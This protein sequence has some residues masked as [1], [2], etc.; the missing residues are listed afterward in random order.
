MLRVLI[1]LKIILA[2]NRD[3]L[4]HI[5]LT[6]GLSV[7]VWSSFLLFNVHVLGVIQGLI[8]I[9]NCLSFIHLDIEVPFVWRNVDIINFGLQRLDVLVIK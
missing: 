5:V 3:C 4:L 2:F 6:Y 7:C 1:Q 8:L 9:T